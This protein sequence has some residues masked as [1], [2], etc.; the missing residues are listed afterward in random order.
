[1]VIQPASWNWTI[2]IKMK[3][4][5]LILVFCQRTSENGWGPGFWIGRFEPL[6]IPVPNDSSSIPAIWIIPKPS[7]STNEQV[8]G[9]TTKK[10]KR[11]Q[12]HVNRRYGT[13]RLSK[14]TQ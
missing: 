7:S 10:R 9:P 3:T 6:G 11:Y 2:E 5:W 8:S 12:T 14:E 13:R 4:S 1:M